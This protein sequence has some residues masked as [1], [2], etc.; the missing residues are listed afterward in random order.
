MKLK[1]L[2]FKQILKLHLLK[3][4]T[5]EQSL[6]NNNFNLV[7]EL[8]LNQIIINFKKILQV[9]FQYHSQNKRIL[10]I[11][12]PKKLELKINKTTNHVAVSKF[13]NIQGLI[14]N[15]ANVNMQNT[16]H[17]L[18]GFKSLLPKLSKRP[19]LVVLISHDKK[20][21]I[22][23]ECFVA[24]TP[25]IHFETN[26]ESKEIWS[27]YSHKVQLNNNNLSLI[28]NKNIFFMGLN[29][30]FKISK[31]NNKLFKPKPLTPNTKR[32]Q[33]QNFQK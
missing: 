19:D 27:I 10:F 28:H 11:G 4:R 20:Q 25:I 26:N 9:I 21:N 16:K 17:R 14:S 1:R 8:T 5:Y 15:N 12:I 32:F 29:F 31:A 30:L 18:F 23:K 6:K 24:K 2:Q 13:F 33:K 22:L 7:T 3:Y